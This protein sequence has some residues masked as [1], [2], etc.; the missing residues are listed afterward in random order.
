M[1]DWQTAERRLLRD[2]ILRPLIQRVGPCTMEHI[3]RE[4]Y[5]ALVRAISHQQ[6]HARVTF[7]DG[8][9][10]N[11]EYEKIY[12][13][14]LRNQFAAHSYDAYLLLD[15][16]VPV[17]LKKGK[18]GTPEFRA[19][20]KEALENTPALAVT[21]GVIDF[22]PTDHWGFRPDT[23]VVMKVVNGDWHLEK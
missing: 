18:P 23:G 15:K 1:A 4:P 2:K 20:L 13:A 9:K 7:S 16:V 17:A 19:A 22:T 11:A 10:F 6:V 21:H 14:G 12:G 5:E 8:V 3:P